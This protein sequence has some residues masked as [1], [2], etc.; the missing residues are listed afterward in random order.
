[1]TWLNDFWP[2]FMIFLP[3]LIIYYL[4]WRL[5]NDLIEWFMTWI[6]DLWPDWVIYDLIGWYMTWLN[7]FWPD[8]MIYYLI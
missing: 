1:M 6:E 5:L 4:I 3:D 2:D 8:F 7:D